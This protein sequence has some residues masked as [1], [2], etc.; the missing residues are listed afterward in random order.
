MHQKHG[1]HGSHG[2]GGFGS[3]LKGPLFWLALFY[4]FK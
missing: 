2:H 1:G 3:L 4:L